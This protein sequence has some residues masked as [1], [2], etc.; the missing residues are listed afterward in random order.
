MQFRKSW[1]VA[2]A[3]LAECLLQDDQS[4]VSNLHHHN[5][6][7]HASDEDLL[8]AFLI[9][10]PVVVGQDFEHAA[11]HLDGMGLFI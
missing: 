7:F 8:K 2:F 4:L 9:D 6:C 3:Y 10:V 11:N 5:H 1:S